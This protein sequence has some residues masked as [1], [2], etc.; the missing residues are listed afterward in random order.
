MSSPKA[1]TDISATSSL[2]GGPG[3]DKPVQ[4]TTFTLFPKFPQEIQAMI[5]EE[6][7]LAQGHQSIHFVQLYSSK[8]R[9]GLETSQRVRL[10]KH[11]TAAYVAR[12][13]RTCKA[14]KE[15]IERTIQAA[16]HN[17]EQFHAI[18][19][20]V[21][22][23]EV[24]VNVNVNDIVSFGSLHNPYVSFAS[25]GFPTDRGG[26]AEPRTFFQPL[27]RRTFRVPDQWAWIRRFAMSCPL[28]NR[29]AE[30]AALAGNTGP[31]THSLMV[32]HLCVA[33]NLSGLR[34]LE[35]V[36]FIVGGLSKPGKT[37]T[38]N[39]FT[40]ISSEL[41]DDT[42]CDI[43]GLL[44]NTRG[45]KT[46]F[47]DSNGLADPSLDII[48]GSDHEYYQVRLCYNGRRGAAHHYIRHFA[49][50]FNRYDKR[51]V[52]E[53]KELPRADFVKFNLLSYTE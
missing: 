19:V 31:S 39:H 12:M 28:N 23:G 38:Y 44:E 9:Q 34:N 18:T 26:I 49:I 41:D 16:I 11:S 8:N 1:T 43:F 35:E 25:Q 5:W 51:R 47:T 15:T 46:L 4:L 7:I 50:K 40:K 24:Q 2:D 42:R 21:H 13:K 14:L 27:N 6:A 17:D 3:D 52:Q 33:W 22:F 48:K 20:S 30:I 10:D 53:Y 37:N 36:F 29:L 45:E 32:C